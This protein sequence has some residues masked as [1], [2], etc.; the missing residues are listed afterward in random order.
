[1]FLY[2]NKDLVDVLPLR[3]K[4]FKECGINTDTLEVICLKEGTFAFLEVENLEK[5]NN[6]KLED[7]TVQTL[8]ERQRLLEELRAK[9]E[10]EIEESMKNTNEYKISALEEENIKLKEQLSTI[11]ASHSDLILDL[12]FRVMDIEDRLE[13]APVNLLNILGVEENMNS[14]FMVVLDKIETGN[15]KTREEIENICNKYLSR[16]RI[17]EEEYNTLMRALDKKEAEKAEAEK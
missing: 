8:E 15:Y 1:M 4:S 13:I 11:R 14:T 10:Q 2:T 12:D 7:L 3:K 17:N 16:N 9:Q 5:Y 6:S